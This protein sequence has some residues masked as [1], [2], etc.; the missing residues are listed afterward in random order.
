[1]KLQIK[2]IYL[3]VLPVIIV[4][5]LLTAFTNPKIEDE[6]NSTGNAN[7][8]KFSHNVHKDIAECDVCHAAVKTS[9]SVKDR[10]LPNH[11]ICKQCHEEVNNDDKC[12]ICH[13]GEI[14]PTLIQ[15]SSNNILFDHSFHLDNQ[16]LKCEAC[17]KGISDVDYAYK[18]SSAIPYY[19]KLL[20]MP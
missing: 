20:F 12:N 7:I 1:M 9:K 10:L 18:A 8:I 11:E 3:V 5:L 4:F 13:Y 19:G 16:K 17:H 6:S 15:H 14:Y 2:Y